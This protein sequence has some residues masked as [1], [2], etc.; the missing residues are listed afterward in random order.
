MDEQRY[1]LSWPQ[2]WKR[3]APYS[4]KRAAFKQQGSYLTL[5]MGLRRLTDELRRLGASSVI[6]STNVV[7]R[8][9]GM[10]R[11]GQAEP[12]DPGAAVYFKLRGKPT[13]LACDTWTKVADNLAAIAAHIECIRGIDRYGVGTLEQAFAGYQAL[14][15]SAE[16]WRTV[17]GLQGRPAW[18][19]VEARHRELAKVHHPDVGGDPHM[20]A[21]LN[22]AKDAARVELTSN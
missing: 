14:P 8:L 3:T 2:G 4:R 17:F 18:E 16:D 1:P 21:K 11:S 10:P 15:P 5:A 22:G 9:D 19:A 6:I 20:M 13:T 12:T 7:L